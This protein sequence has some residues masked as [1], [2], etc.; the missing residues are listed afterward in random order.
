MEIVSRNRHSRCCHR[1]VFIQ[2]P[3]G[4]SHFAQT[5]GESVLVEIS[6]FGPTDHA[7]WIR[8]MN[9]R[10]RS[11]EP[12]VNPAASDNIFGGVNPRLRHGN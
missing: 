9:R 8:K 12:V 3:G 7:T 1:E 4:V 11:V 6:G 10:N 5:G 2:K